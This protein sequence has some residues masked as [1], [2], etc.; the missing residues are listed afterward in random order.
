MF[1]LETET[2]VADD[3]ERLV[4]S[5]PRIDRQTEQNPRDLYNDHGFRNTNYLYR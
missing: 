5:V 4:W 1:Y 2:G 3:A